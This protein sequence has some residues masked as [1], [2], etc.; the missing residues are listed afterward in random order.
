MRY[1]VVPSKD[2][3]AWKEFLD[4]YDWLEKGLSIEKEGDERGIP[5]SS[6]F[7]QEIPES[8]RQFKIVRKE[9]VKKKIKNYLSYLE[10]LIGVEKFRTFSSLW[11]H[12]YDQIGDIIIIK[13]PEE[14]EKFSEQ[15]G[16]ALLLYHLSFTRVFQ[17]LGVHGKFRVRSVKLIRGPN[18][19]GGETKVK[20]NG[21]EFLV[22]PT[23]GYYSPRLAN[24][25]METLKSAILLK[26][27]LGRSLN[28]CDAYAGFGPA[29]LPLLKENNL[30]K[31]VLANDLNLR[32]NKI[33]ED[34]LIH[35][36]KHNCTIKIECL[37]ALNLFRYDEY[38]GFFDILLVNLPHST[39]EH[40]P[41]LIRLLNKNSTSL[42]RAWCIIENNK[43]N[44]LENHICK[45]F[46]TQEYSV[47]KIN[48]KSTRT[49]SPTQNYV[50]IEV[51][52]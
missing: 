45:I 31:F 22:D 16:D 25:R 32:I 36:N 23:K 52:L 18:N 26:E 47:S 9:V 3:Q 17:D 1:L 33:L 12:S 15:I 21:V 27:K 39:V 48:I 4:S 19:L 10:E 35:C 46:N 30:A 8:L 6:S 49:Y 14:I 38:I 34:N 43:L 42:L 28:I 13:I 2:T 50:N 11:P 20:E 41:F 40:L 7:P 51:W 44:E 5:L 24:E 37:D 29:L